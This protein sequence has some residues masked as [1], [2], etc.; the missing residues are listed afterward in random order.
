MQEM[1]N[2]HGCALVLIGIVGGFYAFVYIGECIY[3][4]VCP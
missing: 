1:P 4:G 2:F 3:R